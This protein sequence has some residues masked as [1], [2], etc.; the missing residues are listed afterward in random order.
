M[1]SE[2]EQSEEEAPEPSAGAVE[3]HLALPG[4]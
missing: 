2:A 4:F 3:V 1:T